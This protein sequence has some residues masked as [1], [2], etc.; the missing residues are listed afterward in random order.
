MPTRIPV[1]TVG[2]DGERNAGILEEQI[3]ETGEQDV[4]QSII[5]F[6]K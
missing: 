4:M 6:K 2:L 5:A 1:A 3:I